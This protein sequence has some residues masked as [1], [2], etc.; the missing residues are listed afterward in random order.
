MFAQAQASAHQPSQSASPS[1]TLPPALLTPV[2]ST[3]YVTESSSISTGLSHSTSDFN[4]VSPRSVSGSTTSTAY[5]AS[6]S[7]PSKGGPHALSP[8]T[9]QAITAHAQGGGGGG[10]APDLRVSVP[11]YGSNSQLGNGNVNL[12]HSNPWQSNHHM[13]TGS[14]TQY[15]QLA[16]PSTRASWDLTYLQNL[17]PSPVTVGAGAVPQSGSS[18]GGAGGAHGHSLNSHTLNAY[19]HQNG[20]S[21]SPSSGAIT[22]HQE[23]QASLS[24][25]S[26]SNPSHQPT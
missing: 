13:A 10:G 12:D 8:H 20:H 3:G 9:Q 17:E 16:N 24:G 21:R 15:Q 5:C 18:G 26:S 19:S 1:S 4:A 7:L 22:S 14:S 25:Q 6:N 11:S 23:N 2:S